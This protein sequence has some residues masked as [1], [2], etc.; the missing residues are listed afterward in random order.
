MLAYLSYGSFSISN[1]SWS[2]IL[3]F[4]IK[5]AI[6]VAV[7]IVF[8]IIFKIALKSVE[9]MLTKKEIKGTFHNFILSVIKVVVYIVLILT[10]LGAFN[11][12]TTP[13]LTVLGTFGLALGLALKDHMAN[14][15][16]GILIIVNKQFE[17]GDYISCG[18]AEGIVVKLELF[19][20]KLKSFDNKIVYVPNS[21]FTKGAITNYTKESIRR[22]DVNIGVS[23]NTKIDS[24]RKTVID[25]IKNNSKIL[26]EPE[27]FIGLN[28]FGDNS[29]NFVVRV[30]TETINYWE[31]YFYI[32]EAIKQS[33]DKEN[34]EI[35]YP[36]LDIHMNK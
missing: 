8:R 29:L 26:K 30:W 3:D 12:D 27:S 18:G 17:L 21:A 34:I 36:Q 15:A 23:Y 33:F 31:V 28:E 10:L 6:V 25:I 14:L 24:V 9:K 2:S 16:S 4:I 7:F 19:N 1:W 5:V 20:T 11:V 35:P 22:V 13:L 32:N